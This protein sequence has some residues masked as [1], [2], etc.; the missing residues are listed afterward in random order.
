[1]KYACLIFLGLF[2]TCQYPVLFSTLPET[3][4]I[5]IID[6]EVTENFAKLNVNYSLDDVSSTGAYTFPRPP[7]ANAYLL[8]SKGV[9]YTFKN[10]LGAKDTLFRGQ[11]GETYQLFVEAD[12]K[13]YE[14]L[15]ETMRPSPELDTVAVVYS[16]ES[17]RSPDDLLYDGFDV[18]TEAQDLPGIENY[19]QWAWIHYE[20]A[21][22]CNKIYS[23]SL[24]TDLLVPCNPSD[25]WNITANQK[26]IVQSDKLRDGAPL[27]KYI[28]RVPFAY[29]PEK[30]YLR[31]E[32][33]A[34][35]PLVYDYLK[36]IELNTQQNGTLF[37]IP[38]QTRFNPNVHNLNDKTEKLLGS[39]S[40][41]SYRYRILYIDMTRVIPGATV[42]FIREGYPYV[43]DPFITA[44]CGED[45]TRTKIKPE[46][47]ID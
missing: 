26:V 36:S 40:V 20:K 10:T 17:F 1:M 27:A 11:I 31:V 13:M 43:G 21:P 34:I 41:Y 32:Q 2:F 6:A 16:R 15:K 47:W 7:Q 14:S 45:A 18:Y 30:Y 28:V 12:G 42:K 22:Y 29:P 46:G 23:T 19:Y 9:K 3:E 33:R 25:C 39:F 38:P 24:K 35:T 44:P 37:D 5:L 4:K 8:D